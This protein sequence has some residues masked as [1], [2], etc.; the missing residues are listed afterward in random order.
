MEKKICGTCKQE[1]NIIEFSLKN[2]KLNKRHSKCKKCQRAYG[3][4]H[5]ITN[6]RKYLDRTKINTQKYKK[7]NEKFLLEVKKDIPCKDCG[8]FYPHYMMDFD[9]LPDTEKK[10]NVSRLKNSSLSIKTITKEIKK[11]E[12]V[13]S[14]CHRKRTWERIQ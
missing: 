1:L 7:R 9:H 6:K 3:K 4:K 14:N 8:K 2:I 12:L 11:C 10:N 5:Y 13:C